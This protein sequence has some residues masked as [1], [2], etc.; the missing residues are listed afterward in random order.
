MYD[1]H[2]HNNSTIYEGWFDPSPQASRTALT[3]SD[4]LEVIYEVLSEHAYIKAYKK[5]KD[6]YNEE[7]K[8]LILYSNN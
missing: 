2:Q 7:V 6:E 5:K 8:E 1:T 3:P 4:L